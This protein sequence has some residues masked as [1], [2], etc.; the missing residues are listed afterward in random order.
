MNF[1]ERLKPNTEFMVYNPA[2]FEKSHLNILNELYLPLIHQDAAMA[3]I[4]LQESSAYY[5][6]LEIRFHKEIMDA[7]N[8]SLSSFSKTLEKLEGI[9]LV[10][11]FVSDE[12]HDDLFVYELLQPLTPEAF[13]KDPMLSLYLHNHIGPNAYKTKKDRL[14]YPSKPEH[15][16]EVTRKFTEVFQVGSEEGFSIPE[17]SLRKDNASTGPNVDLDDFD[18]DVLFT[19][20]KGTKIDRAFF[21]KEVRML[22]VKLSVLFNLNAY[23]MKQIL[24][25]ATTQYAGIDR[26]QLRYEARKYYQKENRGKLPSM[27]TGPEPQQKEV[28]NS[29]DSYIERLESISPLDRLN[30]IRN[31]QPSDNDL[32]LVT[33]IIAKTSL[34]N[35]VVNLLLEYVYQQKEGNLN[36]P[37]TMK[38][39]RDWEEKG[40]RSAREAYQ[41]IMEFR[42]QRNT[43]RTGPRERQGERRPAWMDDTRKTAP[44]PASNK[45]EDKKPAPEKGAV[46]KTAKDDPELQKMIDDFRKSR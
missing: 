7:L 17:D 36:Y 23:D 33:D 10:R 19:H 34:P 16:T 2:A 43:K 20:L 9:G 27:T 37:Y 38:I 29:N 35:G 13:F 3:Y 45:D 14:C 39:A 44:A 24:L 4:Y 40:I 1:N 11:S 32:K 21:T 46:Q 42:K 12:A 15:F 25:S 30:D 31:H 26:E 41:S 8:T 22:I 6:K 18:F 28:G 5:E